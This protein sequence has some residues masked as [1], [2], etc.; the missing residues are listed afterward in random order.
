MA[1]IE[2]DLHNGIRCKFVS[3]E[4]KGPDHIIGQIQL[5]EPITPTGLYLPEFIELG[6]SEWDND[7]IT[8]HLR[9]GESQK[10]YAKITYNG[11]TSHIRLFSAPAF[12]AVSR[13][14]ADDAAEAEQVIQE[15]YSGTRV[16]WEFRNDCRDTLQFDAFIEVLDTLTQLSGQFG[17]VQFR[18]GLGYFAKRIKDDIPQGIH[19]Y[20]T[21]Q[22]RIQQWNETDHLKRVDLA[23]VIAEK[24]GRLHYRSGLSTERQDLHDIGFDPTRFDPDWDSIVPACWIAHIIL[25]DGIEA[26]KAYVRE[27]PVPLDRRYDDVKSDASNADFGE[28]GQKWGNVVALTV[29]P[30]NNDFQY[31]TYN[32]LNWTAKEYRGKGKFKPMLFGGAREVIPN[33]LP[34]Y[35]KQEAEAREHYSAGHAWRRDAAFEK[36]REEFDAAKRIAKGETQDDYSTNPELLIKVTASLAHAEAK[37]LRGKGG[38]QDRLTKYET[39]ISEIQQ[40]AAEYDVPDYIVDSELE[41]LRERKEE[42]SS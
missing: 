34:T 37:V 30:S 8:V 22:S 31:D 19:S 32:Y 18:S 10:Q 6:D 7:R 17:H 41:F 39:A 40:L 5:S 12:Y 25:T 24:L 33:Y 36:E 29:N 20:E 11:Q 26:A 9:R 23:D 21:L 3:E 13:A 28:R 14:L 38:L 1:W 35:L 4:I 42:I 15:Y 16:E 2:G 27:R